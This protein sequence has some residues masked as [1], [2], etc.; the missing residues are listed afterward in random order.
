MS[1]RCPSCG[2]AAS[3]KFCS[4]CGASLG[5]QRCRQCNAETAAGARFCASCGASLGA[6]GPT[7]VLDVAGARPLSAS[8]RGP[9]QL[10]P[11]AIAGIAVLAFALVLAFRNQPGGTPAVDGPP[12]AAQGGLPDLSQMSPREAFNRLFTRVMTASEQGDTAT[13]NRFT[14]M[15]L[16][17]YRNLPEVDIDARYDVALIH[18]HAGDIDAARALADSIQ[19]EQSKHLFGFVLR[20]A[21]ARFEQQQEVARKAYREYLAV[22]ADELKANRPEYEAHRSMLDNFKQTALRETGQ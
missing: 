3:G 19:Q 2:A 13:S 14:P 7:P 4:Q 18:L 12:A 8:A 22:E 16:M 1:G 15:A 20:A 11:F 21:I 10:L 6:A 5:S 9:S 17:A